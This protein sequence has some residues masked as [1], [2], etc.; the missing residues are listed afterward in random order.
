MAEEEPQS[1]PTIATVD[2]SS[3]NTR[4]RQIMR[5]NRP[6]DAPLCSSN[7]SEDEEEELLQQYQQE[8]VVVEEEE[9]IHVGNSTKSLPAQLLEDSPTRTTAHDHDTGR[10]RFSDGHTTTR[11]LSFRSWALGELQKHS[12]SSKSSNHDNTDDNNC[13]D[14]PRNNSHQETSRR[15]RLLNAFTRGPDHSINSQ[16]RLH[17]P[18]KATTF[19]GNEEEEEE[20]ELSMVDLK[21][22]NSTSN[23]N[24]NDDDDNKLKQTKSTTK[25]HDSDV[26]STTTLMFNNHGDKA[27]VLA[28]DSSLDGGELRE[29]QPSDGGD[30]DDDHSHS[31]NHRSSHDS[32]DQNS[33][34]N[35]SNSCQIF[36][37]HDND[38]SSSTDD[39]GIVFQDTSE[40]N[41]SYHRR[42]KQYRHQNKPAATTAQYTNAFRLICGKIINNIHVQRL[43]V[44]LIILNALQ[45]GLATFDFVEDNAHL[46]NVLRQVDSALL[47]IFTIE[48]GFQLVYH[49]YH[50][51]QDGWLC[52]DFIIVICSWTFASL[53][54]FRTFRTLR[55]VARVEVLKKLC[56]A[57]MESLP[58]VTGILFL[59]LL[60]MYIYGVMIT[61]LFGDLY[62][63]GYLDDDY[64]SRLDITL[65]TL[66]QMIT[67]DFAK[68]V[69]QVT[70]LYPYSW[71]IF[72]SYLS[73]TSFILFSLII[74]VVCDAVSVVEHD[75]NLLEE[76]EKKEHVQE[77]ILMLQQRVDYLKNQQVSVMAK[78][79]DVLKE[80]K[81]ENI[82]D[83]DDPLCGPL[84]NI[85]NSNMNTTNSSTTSHQ[86][87]RLE[88][89]NYTN[90]EGEDDFPRLGGSSTF[91]KD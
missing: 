32:D 39:G 5:M 83:E 15:R 26:T 81:K 48:S 41:N 80:L 37:Q 8:V 13:K 64:F 28:E 11:G 59:F 42:Q 61:I 24:N 69:R 79:T 67:L 49:G 50:L 73:F 76:L 17:S 6:T 66:F 33:N 60:F 9:E 62:E 52:F 63:R 23:K 84:S 29:D 30:G 45:M 19:H 1:Q 51:F 22:K 57:L 56:Q 54:V 82:E 31:H 58:R 75:S 16:Q 47:I 2:R 36:L 71:I 7:S 27:A 72:A 46:Q 86:T 12:Y 20:D 3:N 88:E 18:L 10:R 35:S 65:F 68:I 53:Q 25:F 89:D 34:S 91:H 44:A 21:K 55:L 78:V 40:Q 77:R 4:M 38:S 43:I 90:K 14:S 85:T 74:A 70:V 87:Q